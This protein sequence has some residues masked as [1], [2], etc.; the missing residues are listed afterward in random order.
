MAITS[1]QQAGKAPYQIAGAEATAP[2]RNGNT[3]VG[4]VSSAAN[5]TVTLPVDP[6]GNAYAAYRIST[7]AAMWV[8]FGSGPAAA[9]ANAWIVTPGAIWDLVPPPG[10]TQLSAFPADALTAGSVS[11]MGLY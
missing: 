3:T 1:G 6:Q 11:V 4:A 8:C 10:T 5:V 9:S 7:S 2:V